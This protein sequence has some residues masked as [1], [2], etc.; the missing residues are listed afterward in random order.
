MDLGLKGKYVLITG[1]C[2]GIGL[3]TAEEF[4]N[5]GAYVCIT[6]RDSKRLQKAKNYL[7][8][9]CDTKRI[10]TFCGDATDKHDIAKLVES[11]R[12]QWGRLD[13]LIPNIGSGKPMNTNP[14]A[15]DEW[16]RML[17]VNLLGG[18]RLIEA[19]LDMLSRSEGNI[20]MISSVVSKQV[21]GTSYAY[22]ASKNSVLTLVKYMARDYSKNKV[23]INCV[24]PGNVLFEGGRWE[25]I[26]KEKKE[27]VYED[28][29]KNVAMQR[30]GKPE[31]IAAGII[32]L[33]SE[34]AA[35]I[36]GSTLT[37]DGGQTSIV[38]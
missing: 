34:K 29:H 35:F 4:L 33:A 38:G 31:E 1:S 3:A 32:F 14:L 11:I 36:T 10:Q 2:Q 5:E 8:E 18:V 7:E 17:E 24:L 28:I 30:L 6:G 15:V 37:I 9:K 16:Q 27:Q 19:F 22:A 25:E 12:Q 21:F 26:I 20:V 23:R 13:V